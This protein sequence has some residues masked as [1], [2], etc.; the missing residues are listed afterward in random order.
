MDETRR[1]ERF[2]EWSAAH[3]AIVE[4]AARA[5]ARGADRDDL[6]QELL[7]AIWRAIPAFRGDAR[8]STFLYRVVHNAALL[9]R[10]GRRADAD[11][12][13]TIAEPAAPATDGDERRLAALYAAIRR[14]PPVDRSLV[15]LSL[16]GVAYAE[17]AT[18]HGLTPNAV[19]ARLSR[20]RDRLASE[21]ERSPA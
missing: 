1:L 17:M 21:L 18:I 9:W 11:S 19:G 4:R 12:L 6:R 20:A 10:R 2:H 13:E 7:L 16:D 5:F 14:L 8:P 3:A 15:L